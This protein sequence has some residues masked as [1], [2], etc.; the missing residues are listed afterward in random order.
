MTRNMHHKIICQKQIFTTSGAEQAQSFEDI[1]TVWAEVIA[2]SGNLE[3]AARQK[4]VG[5]AYVMRMRYQNILLATRKI[6]WQGKT[7]RVVGLLNPDNRK[8]ILE[9]ELQEDQP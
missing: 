7:Y 9:I 5:P 2:K 3:S 1:A 4:F 6:L 8:R